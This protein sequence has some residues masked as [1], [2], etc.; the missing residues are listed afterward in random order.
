MISNSE[1]HLLFN[2]KQKPPSM[3]FSRD[4]CLVLTINAESSIE[5]TGQVS[6]SSHIAAAFWNQQIDGPMASYAESGKVISWLLFSNVFGSQKGPHWVT[7]DV[8]HEN[9]ARISITW[10]RAAA[11]AA[12]GG[13]STFMVLFW[14]SPIRVQAPGNGRWWLHQQHDWR[15]VWG[16][17]QYDRTSVTK[18][19]NGAAVV[20]LLTTEGDW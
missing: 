5:A 20:L 1:H 13:S 14:Q 17:R 4:F 15:C 18:A 2:R 12:G 9:K 3:L 7:Q 10:G 19:A 8:I 6:E 11:A 16:T